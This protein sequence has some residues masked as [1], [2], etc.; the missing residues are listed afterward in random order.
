MGEPSEIAE[1]VV[2][3]ASPASSYING[4]ILFAD[5]GE[6]STLPS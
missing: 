2:F 4:A 6:I 1:I 3:L 5:G